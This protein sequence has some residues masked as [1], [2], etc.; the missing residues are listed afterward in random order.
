MKQVRLISMPF[1]SVRYPSGALSLLKSLLEKE[2]VGCDVAYLNIAFQTYMGHH[3]I[4][5]GIADL[6]MVGE[7]IFG[8]K[9]FGKEWAE[10]DRGRIENLTAPLLPGGFDVNNAQGALNS[11]RSLA[12]RFVDKCLD[13]LDWDE[14]D[15]IGFSSVYSQHVASLA[16]AKGIKERWPDKIVAFGG[17]NCREEMGLSLLRL[18]PFVDW[19]VNGEAD[20]AFPRAVTQWFSG[21]PPEGIP[22]ILFRHNGRIVDQGS[23]EA[24]DLDLL[25]YPNFDDYFGA[26]KK[27]AP[28]F[29]A[30]APISLEFSRGCWWGKKSQCIFCGLNCRKP[31]YRSKTARRAETEIKALVEQYNVDKVIL[32]DSVLNMAF[33]KNLFPALAEWGRLEELFLEARANLSNDQVQALSYVGVKLFQ[34]GIESLDSEMLDY[35]RKGS[36]LLQNVQFLKWT[37]QYGMYPT[38]NLLYGF[39][40]ENPE[41]YRRMVDLVPLLVHLA[42]PMAVSPVLLVRFSPLFEQREDWG[43]TNVHAHAGYRSL[44]P[45]EQ[46]DLDELAS[47]FDC[48][49]D[50]KENIP[51]YVDPLK[52]VVA[53]W[54]D[55]WKQPEPPSLIY[56]TRPDNKIVMHDTRPCG[57][58]AEVGLEGDTALA[59]LACDSEREFESLAKEI[60]EQ[61]GES[62]G[63]DASLRDSLDDLV[64]RRLMLR[65]NDRYL[66]LAVAPGQD[67]DIS[68][69][70]SGFHETN[71]GVQ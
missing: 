15:I 39:P 19:V 9:L 31:N 46:K 36:S 10:S 2:G 67:L 14:Y 69:E 7:W 45:F 49:F 58:K 66:S 32:T 62:Y 60:Q 65:E 41:A 6:I 11:L 37:R 61:A 17:A 63:G 48:D 20:L 68:E 12:V 27:W 5:E 30:S 70:W 23:G 43:L 8:E 4:Y 22:G 50:G 44:Y 56:Y 42:P 40:G 25:P 33:F 35:M 53:E 21:K 26:L 1:A 29:L 24:P 59:Y 55:S 28:D 47:F 34:P 18:F 71:I 3:E 64:E 38:W 52:D 16:L 54:K 51:S 57:M 13:G